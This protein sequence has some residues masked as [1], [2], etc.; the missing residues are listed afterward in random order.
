MKGFRIPRRLRKCHYGI[1]D[2]DKCDERLFGMK[3]HIKYSYKLW[4]YY[5]K[6]KFWKPTNLVFKP[7]K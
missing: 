6:P 1:I 5:E 3:Y 4:A 7:L 2:Y